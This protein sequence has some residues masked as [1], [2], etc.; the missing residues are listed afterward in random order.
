[1]T[2]GLLR[3]LCADRRAAG[4]AEF[5]M[6]LPLFLVLL[7]GTIDVGRLMWT[8]NRAEKATQ[9]AV[10]F[11]V[12]TDMV[13]AGLNSLDF[14]T[15]GTVIQGERIPASA[16]GG[17][18]CVSNNSAGTSITCTAISPTTSAQL[19]TA[20][21]TAFQN[22]VARLRLVYPQATAANVKVS[23]TWSGHGYAGN[24]EGADVAPL[25]TVSLR[26]LNFR[27]LFLALLGGSVPLPSFSAALTL[28]DGAGNASN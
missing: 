12:V 3:R 25:V 23:Y 1:V 17:A 7:L 19:G 13:P 11:A 22:I 28:E 4:A 15:N 6:V 16:F 21:A 5:A 9:M 8:W 18:D 2:G 10:R 27:P 24:P 14:A 26:N 20:N